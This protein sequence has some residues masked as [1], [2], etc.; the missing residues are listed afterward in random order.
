VLVRVVVRDAEG[1]PVEGLRKEDFKVLDRG[2]EQSISQFEVETSTPLPRTLAGKSA[3]GQ[4]APTPPT[5]I[6][7]NFVGLYFD[8]L[9]TSVA[10]MDFARDAADRYLAV[11]LYLG[12][13]AVRLHW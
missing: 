11:N 5:A 12:P 10:D 4:T 9:N 7:G 13:N 1:K 2:K 6:P 8:D 3:P